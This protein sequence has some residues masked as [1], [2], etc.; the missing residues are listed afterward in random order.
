MTSEDEIKQKDAGAQCAAVVRFVDSL[1]LPVPS[2]INAE[3]GT[4]AYSRYKIAFARWLCYCKTPS[5]CRSLPQQPISQIFGVDFL[6][7]VLEHVKKAM[8]EE[9]SA[10]S[11]YLAWYR[12]YLELSILFK[13]GP[14]RHPVHD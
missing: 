11:T 6:L 13:S 12:Q 3:D 7:S 5:F 8:P 10:Q 1:N 9:E 4:E 14:L 2:K